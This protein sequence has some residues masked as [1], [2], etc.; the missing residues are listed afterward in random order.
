MTVTVV[1]TASLSQVPSV[2]ATQIRERAPGTRPHNVAVAYEQM[3]Y[4]L[5]IPRHPHFI[6]FMLQIVQPVIDQMVQGELTPEEAGRRAAKEVNAFFD[7][8][9][10]EDTQ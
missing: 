1:E 2:A 4:A 9:S 3:K 6:E 8:F 7:T 5:P 10:H